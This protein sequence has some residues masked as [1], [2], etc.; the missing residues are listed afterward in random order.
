MLNYKYLLL[1][2]PL[3]TINNAFGQSTDYIGP[4]VIPNRSHPVV[5]DGD[6]IGFYTFSYVIKLNKQ[7][8]EEEKSNKQKGSAI[9][10]FVDNVKI[11]TEVMI[12]DTAVIR[13]GV[14]LTKKVPFSIVEVL[15]KDYNYNVTYSNDLI[16]AEVNSKKASFYLKR[17]G[18]LKNASIAV[19]AISATIAIVPSDPDS[20]NIEKNQK[21]KTIVS[22]IGGVTSLIL[23]IVGNSSLIKAG[24]ALE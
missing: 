24:E 22:V 15:V 10:R 8:K 14:H 19:A 23:N 12:A 13:S 20:P 1:F 21:S 2:I 17:A 18:K 9:K 4:T 5:M 7:S 6:T 16:K 3:L 11:D